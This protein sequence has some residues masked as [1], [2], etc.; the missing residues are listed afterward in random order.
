MYCC[1]RRDLAGECVCERWIYVKYYGD[2]VMIPEVWKQYVIEV[3]EGVDCEVMACEVVH[4]DSTVNKNH[5]PLWHF[6]IYVRAPSVRLEVV[7]RFVERDFAEEMLKLGF[8]KSSCNG[9]HYCNPC[10]GF[11][12]VHN[13]LLVRHRC[14][15]NDLGV[16]AS[17]YF[18]RELVTVLFRLMR[19]I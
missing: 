16:F 17:A 11:E 19:S 15:F 7:C 3:L 1:E 18:S 14:C 13:K 2:L 12:Q 5:A 10:E 4:D 8:F 9:C 6:M